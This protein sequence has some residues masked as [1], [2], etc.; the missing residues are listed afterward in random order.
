MPKLI[1][2][3]SVCQGYGNCV[4]SAPDV[5]DVDD[6]GLVVL[7]VDTIA[8]LDRDGIEEAVCGCPVNALSIVD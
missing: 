7:L 3:R 5:Y 6:D 2:D 1:A 4:V 8:D